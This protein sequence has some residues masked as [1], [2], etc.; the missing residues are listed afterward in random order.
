MTPFLARLTVALAELSRD[1]VPSSYAV[2]YS[3]GRDSTVL[4]SACHRLGLAAPLRALHVDH[5]L[6]DDS[7]LW[8]Q[9]C[10]ET[11][12]SLG[13]E[14]DSRRVSVATA[15]GRGT[16]AAARQA[17]YDAL[18]EMLLPGEMLLTAHHQDDQL[19]T[20]LLRLFRGAGVKG[21]RGISAHAAFGRGTLA[22]PLLGFSR[23]EIRRAAVGLG[24]AWIEDPSNADPRF[25]RS[26]LR[27]AVLPLLKQRWPA[28]AATVSRT[29][30][31][32][33]DAQQLL[34]RVAAADASGTATPARLPRQAISLLSEARQRNLLRHF[35][36]A[37]GLPLPGAAQLEQVLAALRVERRD[38]Q[39]RVAWPG[40]EVRL[41]RDTLYLVSPLGPR[42]GSKHRG[43]VAPE[44]P[45]SGPEGRVELIAD[46]DAEAP[47]LPESWVRD[48]LELRF[49]EGGERFKPL[50]ARYS[51]A[52]KKLL[53]DAGVVP[54][55][56]GRVPLLYR[57]DQIVAVGDLWVCDGVRAARGAA[58]TW[59]IGWTGHPELY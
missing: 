24:L 53:Q 22:R 42:S 11:A 21:L 23:D 18:E 6:H 8:A 30:R 39:P 32:M 38:A 35:I 51:R 4:L 37:N 10:G 50:R 7:A 34:E 44:Q 17:R 58:T 5:G 43:R 28:V 55:M 15:A 2:A 33:R 45:W 16:E 27:A 20:V 46:G 47:G 26:F 52:L 49:R 59:R 48:G 57:G 29:A 9:R 25:D 56:R 1:P 12:T 13:V 14:F 54:W 3:G 41:F 19:E 31:Q 40:A 36:E